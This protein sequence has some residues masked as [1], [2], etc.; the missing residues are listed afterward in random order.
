MFF[1]LNAFSQ[2]RTLHLYSGTYP[3]CKMAQKGAQSSHT[4]QQESS[5]YFFQLLRCTSC[6]FLFRS[7]WFPYYRNKLSNC[8]LDLQKCFILHQNQSHQIFKPST[9]IESLL[10]QEALYQVHSFNKQQRQIY[11]FLFTEG[12]SGEVQNVMGQGISQFTCNCPVESQRT[13][14]PLTA[15]KSWLTSRIKTES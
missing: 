3:P 10:K 15:D 7:I 8:A 6:I 1:F 14:V 13:A 9:G 4:K 12:K 11:K 2:M 5:S